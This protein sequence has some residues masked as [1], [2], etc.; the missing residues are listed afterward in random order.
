MKERLYADMNDTK[1]SIVT[2]CYNSEP[3]LDRIYQSILSLDHKNIEW[4]TVDD[5]SPDN[6]LKKLHALKDLNEIPVKILALDQNTRGFEAARRGIQMATGKFTII[7][8]HDDELMPHSIS[9]LVNLWNKMAPPGEILYGVWGRCVDENNKPLGKLYR[10]L[11]LICKNGYFFHVL[12]C[13][14]ECFIMVDTELLKQYYKLTGNQLIK[15]NGAIWSEMGKNYRSLFTNE[16][17]RKYYTNIPTSQTN[18]K[19]IHNSLSYS[20]QEAD[21]LNEN[22]AFFARDLIFFL[23]KIIVYLNYSYHAGVSIKNAI[24]NLDYFKLRMAAILLVPLLP[25]ILLK[26]RLIN[27][28]TYD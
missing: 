28:R 7:L 25:V 21:Y 17:V 8:D 26:N 12:K 19:R 11:P 16:L 2:A 20:Y 3:F 23:R 1:V 14:V 18:Q 13:R 15:T 4:I 27:K 5:H 9:N 24:A 22:N 6:T 10:E